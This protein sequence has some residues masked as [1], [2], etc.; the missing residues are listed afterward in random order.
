M[1]T[2]GAEIKAKIWYSK[3][4]KVYL[5]QEVKASTGATETKYKIKFNNFEINF[6]KTLSK[7][8]NYDT[9]SEDKKLVIFSNFYLPVKVEKITNYEYEKQDITYTEEELTKITED[10][11]K[12]QLEMRN[13]K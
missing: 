12:N 5:N 11:L 6:Y 3:K 4:E 10:K 1:Y 9:I 7:F 8:K 13:T 2:L